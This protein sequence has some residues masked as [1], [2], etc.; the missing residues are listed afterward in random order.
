ME[1]HL[2]QSMDNSALPLQAIRK[3][4]QDAAL[5]AARAAAQLKLGN[6]MEALEDAGKAAELQPG[7]AKA[8][9]RKG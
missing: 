9:L 8:H 6:N 7:L 5:F 3:D 1:A 2:L 4:S